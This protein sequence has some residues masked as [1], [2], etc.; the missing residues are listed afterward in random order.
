[1]LERR[2]V[3]ATS[4]GQSVLKSTNLLYRHDDR[5]QPQVP[6][7]GLTAPINVDV[8]DVGHGQLRLDC[9]HYPKRSGAKCGPT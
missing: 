9:G 4:L 8:R 2:E 1:L 5:A 7:V 6:I 3:P